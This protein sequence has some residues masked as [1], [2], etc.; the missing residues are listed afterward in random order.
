MA[1]G[2]GDD[3]VAS[4]TTSD[5]EISQSPFSP[6]GCG[7]RASAAWL[8]LLADDPHPLV[9]TPRSETLAPA[10]NVMLLVGQDTR[11][12]EGREGNHEGGRGVTRR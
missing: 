4:S 1:K 8:L 10:T 3:A 7:G 5:K 6:A 9:L 11:V 12:G 2:G